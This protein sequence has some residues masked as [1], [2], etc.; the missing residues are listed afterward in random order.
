MNDTMSNDKRYDA[1]R[2]FA[3]SRG[4]ADQEIDG[5]IAFVTAKPGGTTVA[6][7]EGYGRSRRWPDALTKDV[8]AF[9]TGQID[10]KTN[11]RRPAPAPAAP[12]PR[13][14]TPP[15]P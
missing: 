10:P 4:L 12:Q 3:R 9:A 13:D 11:A 1:W 7:L 5:A 15:A 2:N 6:G 8:V 14:M